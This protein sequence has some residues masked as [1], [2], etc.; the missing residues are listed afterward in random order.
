MQNLTLAPWVG[1]LLVIVAVVAGHNFRKSW[2]AGDSKT[3]LW[4]FG[5]LAAASLLALGLIP[6]KMIQA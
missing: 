4:I 6:L 1:V 2:V 3:R 5:L